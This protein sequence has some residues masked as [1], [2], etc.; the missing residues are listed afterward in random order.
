MG[1]L[2][3]GLL[4]FLVRMRR[5]LDGE[6]LDTGRERDGSGHAGAG[7]FDGVGNFA[8]RLVY[9]PM[10]I[11]LKSNSNALG[12]HRKNNCLLMV[13]IVLPLQFFESGYKV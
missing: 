13:S 3:E 10:V 7:A 8:R 11:G 5:A 4:R 6:T 1:A 12:S 9:D 2:L